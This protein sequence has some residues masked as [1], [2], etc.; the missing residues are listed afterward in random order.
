MVLVDSSIWIEAARRN[1]D[2][3]CKVALEGLLEA[4]EAAFCGP[5]RLEVLGGARAQDRQRMS[6]Y[7][8]CIPYQAI[9]DSA[10]DRAKECAWRLC[11]AGHAIPWNDIVI[12]SLSLAWEC[13]VYARD[14][15]FEVMQQVLKIRLYTPGYGGMYNAG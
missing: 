7:F 5:I 9:N 4:A 12:G 8:D 14:A 6:A 10:W 1:G 2:L 3:L 15:H 13:R 11:D